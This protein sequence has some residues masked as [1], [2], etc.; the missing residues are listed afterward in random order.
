[1][2]NNISDGAPSYYQFFNWEFA[3]SPSVTEANN[4]GCDYYVDTGKQRIEQRKKIDFKCSDDEFEIVEIEEDVV[5]NIKKKIA[6]L[7]PARIHFLWE[8]EY[9]LSKKETVSFDIPSTTIVSKLNLTQKQHDGYYY[10]GN[11]LVVFDG[12]LTGVINGLVI[13]KDY[14]DRFLKENGLS[15]IW[16]FVGEKQYFTQTPREQYYS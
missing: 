1:M 7:Q 8:E 12:E 2:R 5:V 6:K 9:D 13:R 11:D 3:W 10:D 16:D 15:I 14:L 4:I